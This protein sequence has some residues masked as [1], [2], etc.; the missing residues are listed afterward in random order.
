MALREQTESTGKFLHVQRGAI[1]LKADKPTEG[2][3]EITGEVDGVPF[4]TYV[5][6]FAA[7]DGLITKIAWEV[8]E[9]SGK[10][11]RG[12]KITI[13]DK[14]ENYILDLPFGKRQYDMFTKIAENIDYEK[15]VEFIAWQ[16]KQ[17][18]RVTAFACKQDGKFVQWKYTREDMG[19]CP[20]PVKSEI[21][22]KWSF[23]AQREWLLKR[24]I[25]VVIPHVDSIVRFDEPTPE[26]DEPQFTGDPLESGPDINATP[27][28]NLPPDDIPF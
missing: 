25:E 7:V 1:C 21:T 23:D 9:H 28:D 20:Q 17:D 27:P 22:G 19:D 26:Y 4:T 3:E 5:K 6:K 12:L 2:Y 11:Y 18:E 15:P 14:G 13:K 16:D 8:R 10:T 24:I